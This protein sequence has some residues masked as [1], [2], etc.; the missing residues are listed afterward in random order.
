MTQEERL[1][2]VERDFDEMR[3]LLKES[4][5]RQEDNRRTHES[6]LLDHERVMREMEQTISAVVAGFKTL[7]EAQKATEQALKAFIDSLKLGG[8]GRG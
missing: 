3:E 8:N 6:W 2:R 1:D 7:Q 5:K 4:L